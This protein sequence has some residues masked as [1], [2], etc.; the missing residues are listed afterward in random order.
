MKPLSSRMVSPSELCAGNRRLPKLVIPA[1]TGGGGEGVMGSLGKGGLA[2][3]KAKVEGESLPRRGLLG[4]VGGRHR[5]G[6]GDAEVEAM[7]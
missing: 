7:A 1:V 5:R 6:E 4:M 2:R 3:C